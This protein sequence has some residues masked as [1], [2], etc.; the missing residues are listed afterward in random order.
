MRDE[1]NDARF[2]H[3]VFNTS[4]KSLDI[5]LGGYQSGNTESSFK[6]FYYVKYRLEE[7]DN[8]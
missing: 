3:T 2:L 7:K 1:C 6:N 8:V 5:V 4:I